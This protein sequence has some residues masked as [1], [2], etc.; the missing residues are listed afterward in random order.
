[1]Y[2]G[3]YLTI[4]FELTRAKERVLRKLAERDW[5]PTDLADELETSR[6]S[7]Y[8]HLDELDRLGVLTTRKVAGKTRPRTEYSIGDGFFQYVAVLPGQFE[9]EA[10]DVTPNKL[11]MFRIWSVPQPEFHPFIE[12]YWFELRTEADVEFREDVAAVGVYGSVARGDA[13]ADSDID[14]LVVLE[15]E[16]TEQAVSGAKI[17]QTDR[18]S[19]LCMTETFG[20]QEYRDSLARGSDFLLSVL[21]EIRPIYDPDRLFQ[22]DERNDE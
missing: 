4:V 17:I 22:P 9:H 6:Q 15:S 2:S 21:D 3:E 20:R 11:A 1:M 18:G 5:T 16:A 14:V 10:L 12:R 19:K 8:N 7:A 13:D